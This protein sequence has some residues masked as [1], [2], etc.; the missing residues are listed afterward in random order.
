M[1][2]ANRRRRKKLR[3]ELIDQGK[4]Q[5]YRKRLDQYITTM[6]EKETALVK[7]IKSVKDTDD[8]QA[9]LWIQQIKELKGL[10]GRIQRVNQFLENY[11]AK[12]E[13]ESVYEDF[14]NYLNE[15]NKMSGKTPSKRKSRKSINKSQRKI[16]DLNQL[17]EYIDKKIVK[18]EK[19]D[20]Q[21]A[22][23]SDSLDSIDVDAFLKTYE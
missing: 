10:I 12:Q 19:H 18:F 20:L 1:G 22:K 6:Q 21:A 2:W 4:L 5:T 11:T 7:N 3:K 15:S 16:K 13:T 17:F 9:K 23:E 8:F 14:L